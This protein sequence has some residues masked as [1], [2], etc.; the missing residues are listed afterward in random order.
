MAV[1]RNQVLRDFIGA[2]QNGNAALFIGAG[3]SMSA[4]F[5]NWKELL[6]SLAEEIGLDVNQGPDLVAIAQYH[7]NRHGQDR[8]RLNQIVRREFDKAVRAIHRG[9]QVVKPRPFIV[10]RWEGCNP[11]R[12]V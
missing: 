3:L 6:R 9:L 1:D 2:A 5:V 11:S 4:G 8:S 10:S 12:P 7:L